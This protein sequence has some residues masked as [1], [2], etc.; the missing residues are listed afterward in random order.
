MCVF[1]MKVRKESILPDFY[2]LE[3]FIEEE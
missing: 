1:E 2:F 3:S